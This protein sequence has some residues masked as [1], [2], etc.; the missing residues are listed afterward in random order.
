MTYVQ[1]DILSLNEDEREVYRICD[2]NTELREKIGKLALILEMIMGPAD[3]MAK[4]GM[5]LQHTLGDDMDEASRA[6]L[7]FYLSLGYGSGAFLNCFNAFM[8]SV[9][10]VENMTQS[11]VNLGL[12]TDYSFMPI[13]YRDAVYLASRANACHTIAYVNK[14]IRLIMNEFPQNERTKITACGPLLYLQRYLR[15]VFQM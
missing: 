3:Y 14:C 13:E 15:G 9:D 8:Q 11:V 1:I 5:E 6:T 12:P 7:R 2:P 4:R 10:I